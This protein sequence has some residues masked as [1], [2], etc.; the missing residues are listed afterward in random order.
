M[1]DFGAGI[2]LDEEFAEAVLVVDVKRD[3]LEYDEEVRLEALKCAA[4]KGACNEPQVGL[5]MR[6]VVLVCVGE[7]EG[8]EGLVVKKEV[9]E[10]L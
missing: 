7:V 1:A 5:G 6:M 9:G 10:G 2:S 4:V 3:D 8:E